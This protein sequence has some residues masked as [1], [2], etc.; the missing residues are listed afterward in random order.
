MLHCQ[1]QVCQANTQHSSDHTNTSIQ[2]RP[3]GLHILPR[4]EELRL[5]VLCHGKIGSTVPNLADGCRGVVEVGILSQE[6]RHSCLQWRCKV[7]GPVPRF[8]RFVTFSVVSSLVGHSLCFK[9]APLRSN[10][11]TGL[12]PLFF[13]QR[14]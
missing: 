13:C 9:V 6:E 2:V 14:G 8:G 11:P 5:L 1:L 4:R 10:S 12:R 3:S 7:G